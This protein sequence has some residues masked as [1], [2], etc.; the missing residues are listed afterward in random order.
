MLNEAPDQLADPASSIENGPR[1][2]SDIKEIRRK[3][4]DITSICSNPAANYGH[5]PLDNFA[6]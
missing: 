4:F 5:I 3:R 1:C 2:R 6:D